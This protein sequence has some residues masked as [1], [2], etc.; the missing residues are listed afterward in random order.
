MELLKKTDYNAKINEIEGK[1]PSIS[2]L[3]TTTALTAVENK[4]PDVS[5]FVKKKVYDAE[6]LD[7]KSKYFTTDDC[8]R[9][10]SEKLDLK[11][12]KKDYLVNLTLLDSL[13][14]VIWIKN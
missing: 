11:I 12:K 4:I 9:F 3:A 13:T 5:N 6:I 1:I 10:T 8:N 7:I 14:I 2:G